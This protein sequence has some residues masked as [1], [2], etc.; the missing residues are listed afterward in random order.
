MT[1]GEIIAFCG[2][3][4]A[5]I[6]VGWKIF[7]DPRDKADL[8]VAAKFGISQHT[9]GDMPIGEPQRCLQVTT[10]NAG[11]RP[12]TISMVGGKWKQPR[13]EGDRF[14]FIPPYDL[15]KLLAPGDPP[16][17]E[18]YWKPEQLTIL[19]PDLEQI[20]VRDSVGKYW[21][22]NKKDIEDLRVWGRVINK[23]E[24]SSQS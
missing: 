11:R 15:P 18:I 17:T 8:K 10:T 19:T 13:A 4:V 2:V 14:T 12:I 7:Q 9:L 24:G 23:Q 3:G 16:H 6:G 21:Y 20:W 1:L 5:A 22:A